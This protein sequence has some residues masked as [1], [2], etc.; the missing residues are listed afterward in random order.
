M[1]TFVGRTGWLLVL[2]AQVEIARLTGGPTQLVACIIVA[3]SII[4]LL[5]SFRERG[6]Q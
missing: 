5:L 6:A 1:S 3:L 4:V 2:L